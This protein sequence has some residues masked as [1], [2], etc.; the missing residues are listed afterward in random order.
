MVFDIF[1]YLQILELVDQTVAPVY[2]FPFE[3]T[4][5]LS[6]GVLNPNSRVLK[7][8][9]WATPEQLNAESSFTPGLC[10][11]WGL[12]GGSREI[13]GLGRRL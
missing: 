9:K 12:P 3:M 5:T 11:V 4:Q 10:G 1:Y 7:W 8:E 6:T 2:P 13:E